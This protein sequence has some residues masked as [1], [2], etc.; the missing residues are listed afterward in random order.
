MEA[1]VAA[2]PY[3]AAAADGQVIRAV[4]LSCGTSSRARLMLSRRCHRADGLDVSAKT[5]L[6]SVILAALCMLIALTA[7]LSACHTQRPL[8]AILSNACS[9]RLV[10][11]R[12]TRPGSL[13]AHSPA[14]I[15]RSFWQSRIQTGLGCSSS[16]LVAALAKTMPPGTACTQPQEPLS[17]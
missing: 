5:N 13:G 7:K 4:L 14:A 16:L 10:Q 6:L 12:L 15:L 8:L 9:S 2:A 17:Q 11:T 3:L 1:E